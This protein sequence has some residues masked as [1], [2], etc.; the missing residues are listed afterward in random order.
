M[1]LFDLLKWL[2]SSPPP[3]GPVSLQEFLESKPKKGKLRRLYDGI[4]GMMFLSFMCLLISSI[5]NFYFTHKKTDAIISEHLYS[6]NYNLHIKY[7]Y[8]VDGKLYH[9]R[10]GCYQ[11]N[12]KPNPIG[13]K[14]KFIK[15]RDWS[16]MEMQ[17]MHPIGSTQTVY[18]LEENPSIAELAHRWWLFEPSTWHFDFQ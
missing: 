13:R 10:S 18:Y 4:S 6:D 8:T 16:A 15:I 17:Y 7:D 14:L 12:P 2:F 11:N 1:L 5:A 9:G 3:K